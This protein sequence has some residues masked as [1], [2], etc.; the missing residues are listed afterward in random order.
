MIA[1]LISE[2]LAS[3][4]PFERRAEELRQKAREIFARL[5][6]DLPERPEPQ[7]EMPTNGRL[8]FD[9]RRDWVEQLEI[10]K[11]NQNGKPGH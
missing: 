3:L 5:D 10:F 7:V 6:L 1:E 9:T 2:Q 11:S 4:E 8:L